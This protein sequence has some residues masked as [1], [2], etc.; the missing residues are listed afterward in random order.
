MIVEL[1]KLSAMGALM[2]RHHALKNGAFR[3]TPRRLFFA[4][5][6]LVMSNENIG[7]SFGQ[8]IKR[9]LETVNSVTMRHAQEV[10]VSK[11]EIPHFYLA[12]DVN[13]DRLIQTGIDINGAVVKAAAIACKSVPEAAACW[14]PE[15][16]TI[17]P[18]IGDPGTM[19][20]S[21]IKN[22]L[23]VPRLDADDR[24]TFTIISS[25]TVDNVCAIINPRQSCVLAMG[26]VKD[27]VNKEGKAVKL[28]TFNL[29]CDHRVID[30]AVGAMWLQCFRK[31]LEEMNA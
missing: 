25:P 13:V 30:G 11:N 21:H 7:Q 19:S 29:S 23:K 3:L 18:V 10:T 31:T 15:N 22:A 8:M 2:R 26:M 5:S 28:V 20:V 4:S 14:F 16:K 17:R 1:S 12:I 27:Q 24:S 9:N 6:N